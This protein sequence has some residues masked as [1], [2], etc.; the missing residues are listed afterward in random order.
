MSIFPLRQL[1]VEDRRV[2]QRARVVPDSPEG[3]CTEHTKLADLGD[4]NKALAD[5]EHT[6]VGCVCDDHKVTNMIILSN[7]QLEKENISQYAVGLS[8]IS[9]KSQLAASGGTEMEE[10]EEARVKKIKT[11]WKIA[12]RSLFMQLNSQE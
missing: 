11:D 2:W 5:F 6:G 7:P 8:E 10:I 12:I 4:K 3:N 9:V 1:L